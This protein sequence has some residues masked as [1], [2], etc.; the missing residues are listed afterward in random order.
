LFK[1]TP[2]YAL[3]IDKSCLALL[4]PWFLK[5]LLS[6]LLPWY[7]KTFVSLLYLQK[8][9]FLLFLLSWNSSPLPGL[10]LPLVSNGPIFLFP[11]P[12]PVLPSGD[13]LCISSCSPNLVTFYPANEGSFSHQ[14]LFLM[15][16][17][18]QFHNIE[19]HNMSF[20]YCECYR[21]LS[22]NIQI[23]QD[24]ASGWTVNCYCHSFR[25]CG[26]FRPWGW[27]QYAPLVSW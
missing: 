23:L 22:N 16:Q 10:W 14:K 27:W 7:W 12:C 9:Y 20:H 17:T 15:Y 4:S 2:L 1:H 13:H 11:W 8:G 24:V 26:L 21:P 19:D 3:P 18:M 6:F 5:G 25:V